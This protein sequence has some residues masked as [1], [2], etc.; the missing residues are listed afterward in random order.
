MGTHKP[1]DFHWEWDVLPRHPAKSSLGFTLV[2]GPTGQRFPVQVF[3]KMGS[4]AGFKLQTLCHEP[5]DLEVDDRCAY[6]STPKDSAPGWLSLEVSSRG[7][8]ESGEAFLQTSLQG[9]LA[10]LIT[11]PLQ[12]MLVAASVMGELDKELAPLRELKRLQ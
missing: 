8:L 2:H 4:T 6:C 3:L 7:V 5:H 10:A 1:D 12:L 11:D 9:H